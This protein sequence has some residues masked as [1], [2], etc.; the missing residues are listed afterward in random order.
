MLTGAQLAGL[1]VLVQQY[2]AASEQL[3][4]ASAAAV[5]AAWM[6]FAGWYDTAAVA[7]LAAQMANLS[8]AN[9]QQAAGAA[10]AYIA[11]V[12]SLM[13]GT[14]MPSIPRDLTAPVRNGADLRLVHQRPAV[15]YRRAIATGK[16]HREALNLAFGRAKDTVISDLSLQ[17]RDAGNRM[18]QQLGIGQYRRIIH[19]ELSA[20]GTCG[21]CIAAADRT[22]SIGELMP[23]HPP[24]C[25]CTV[26][27]VIGTN[28]PGIDLNQDDLDQL[29]AAAGGSTRNEDLRRVRYTVNEHGELGPVL[30]KEGDNFRGPSKV[31]LEDDP[32][33]AL[34]MLVQ[35][36]E[37][38]PKIEEQAAAGRVDAGALDYQR[39]QI[40]RLESIAA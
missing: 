28:D 22:Y 16:D 26:M 24:D 36:R 34:R 39:R 29:Y 20:S 14:R 27:P 18:M 23:L 13:S 33:R 4:T 32:V 9:Q 25:K 1:A 31:A 17:E 19:P 3:Q 21:L 5:E 35:M 8:A 37:N 10:G 40:A 12:T 38:L 15:V 6:S 30:G 2:G 7:A 11:T